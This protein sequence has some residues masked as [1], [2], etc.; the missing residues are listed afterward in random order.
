M[1]G[2]LDG[3]RVIELAGIG[4]GPLAGQLLADLGADVIS[5]DRKAEPRLPHRPKDTNRRNKR[6]IA[7]DLKADGAADIVLR[8]CEKADILFEGFRPGVAERLGLGPDAVH[9]VNPALVYGRL[10]GWGQTGPLSERAGHDIN[11]IA[12][13]GALST[14]GGKDRPIPPLNLVGDYAGGSLMLVYGLMAALISARTSGKGQVVDTAMTDGSAA[15]M[16][17]IHAFL[18][19]GI[20]KKERQANIIDGGTPFYR[21]YETADGGF[22]AV[23]A[24]EPQFFALLIDGLGMDKDWNKRQY[25]RDGWP[26]MEAEFTARFRSKTRAEWSVLFEPVD[27]CVSPVLDMEEARTHPHNQARQTF[28]ELAGYTQPAPA[29]RFSGHELN[30]RRGAFFQ[31]EHTRA[32]L[33]EVGFDASEIDDLIASGK[34]QEA[35]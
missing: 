28:T 34:V 17:L 26:E 6:S 7:I 11:Y 30:L 14:I 27:A 13:S 1:S 21:C 33:S 2:P 32:I 19:N 12:I 25:D 31:G 22:M 15:I 24:L 16:S 3:I 9:A 35:K 20:W 29:P 8:L 10:T 23:G 18:D 4:P 5:I